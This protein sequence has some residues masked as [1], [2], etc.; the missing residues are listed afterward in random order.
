[1]RKKRKQQTRDFDR[2]NALKFFFFFL[3][4]LGTTQFRSRLK[5]VT[6]HALFSLPNEGG[7]EAEKKRGQLIIKLVQFRGPDR[8]GRRLEISFV[9][10]SRQ[11]FGLIF[12]FLG[13]KKAEKKKSWRSLSPFTRPKP[14]KASERRLALARFYVFVVVSAAL[15]NFYRLMRVRERKKERKKASSPGKERKKERKQEKKN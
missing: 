4:F 12:L 13:G 1:M 10:L 6:G 3:L 7:G 8:N 11:N 9:E 5:G 2:I 15:K 14:K